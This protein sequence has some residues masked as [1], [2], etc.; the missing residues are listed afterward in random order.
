MGGYTVLVYGVATCMLFN[1][2]REEYRELHG[3]PLLKDLEERR[4]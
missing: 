4:S 2:R 1:D 3:K